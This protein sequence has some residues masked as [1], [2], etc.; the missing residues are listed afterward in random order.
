MIFQKTTSKFEVYI[1]K[2]YQTISQT[3]GNQLS[4]ESAF[5]VMYLHTQVFSW[6]ET[7]ILFIY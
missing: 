3:K 6:R 1:Y 4:V 5:K 7:Y 2:M